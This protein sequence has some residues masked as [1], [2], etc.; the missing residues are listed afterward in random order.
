M[1]EAADDG[2]LTIRYVGGDLCDTGGASDALKSTRINFEC[3]ETPV[4][5]LVD[6]SY[7][8]IILEKQYHTTDS[9]MRELLGI[10]C[11]SSSSPPPPPHLSTSS[12][13]RRAGWVIMF[14]RVVIERHNPVKVK[15]FLLKGTFF[16]SLQ[17]SPVF[18]SV[19]KSCEYIFTWQTPAACPL[20]V[21]TRVWVCYYA[22]PMK[23]STCLCMCYLL[24]PL[25]LGTLIVP[26]LGTYTH[27]WDLNC[28]GIGYLYSYLRP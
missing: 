27:T 9:I 17:G 4:S 15:G 22:C 23:V 6:W 19:T 20:K 24:C 5:H 25:K 16:L 18:Q 1:P 26:V 12:C 10:C 13:G 14:E 21:C 7:V 8:S 3:S 28:T 2:T 11:P